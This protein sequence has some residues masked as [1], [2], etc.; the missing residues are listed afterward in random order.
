MSTKELERQE[1]KFCFGF[2]RKDPTNP[3]FIVA[4]IL[5]DEGLVA[6]GRYSAETW[7]YLDNNVAVNTTRAGFEA[8][9]LATSAPEF[10]IVYE[11]ALHKGTP[12]DYVRRRLLA[13]T[14]WDE[15]T[16]K[17]IEGTK[18]QQRAKY[19]KYLAKARAKEEDKKWFYTDESQAELR[20]EADEGIA[21][22]RELL[23]G[24]SPVTDSEFPQLL[25][26]VARNAIS[27]ST[28]RQI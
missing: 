5:Q 18:L 10:A 2:I 25:E 19:L 28:Q 4:N 6:I 16:K 26:A 8:M 14:L 11:L 27:I 20:S 21:K 7:K 17:R 9:R 15:K 1:I 12:P 24:L 22:A 3:Y 23:S 13:S